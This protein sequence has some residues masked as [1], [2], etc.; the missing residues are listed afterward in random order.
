MRIRPRCP[1]EFGEIRF[2]GHGTPT[3]GREDPAAAPQAA[4][5]TGKKRGDKK[6]S[7]QV[8]KTGDGC[9]AT[10]GGIRED[11]AAAPQAAAPTG[12]K[13]SNQVGKNGGG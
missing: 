5:Q 6:C 2:Y 7:S 3:N 9:G 11:A 12:N 10:S 1:H 13:T 8:G 4:A